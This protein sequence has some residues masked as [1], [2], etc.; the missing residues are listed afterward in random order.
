LCATKKSSALK[1]IMA[2]V[3]YGQRLPRLFSW[4]SGMIANVPASGRRPRVFLESPVQG[5]DRCGRDS[6]AH[7]GALRRKKMCLDGVKQSLLMP[8]RMHS[9]RETEILAIADPGIFRHL[10]PDAPHGAIRFFRDCSPRPFT[11]IT[12]WSK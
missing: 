8:F 10:A 11:A 12:A 1:A 7:F 5:I 2:I 6:M 9:P 3:M 4:G